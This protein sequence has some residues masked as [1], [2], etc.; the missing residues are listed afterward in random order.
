MKAV[1]LN[2]TPTR[3][4]ALQAVDGLRG[5]IERGE[6]VAFVAVGIMND[7]T[8]EGFVGSSRPVSRLRLHGAIAALGHDVL[9]GKL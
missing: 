6:I 2:Q 5:K 7:D 4:H 3:E 1:E 8:I 9:D